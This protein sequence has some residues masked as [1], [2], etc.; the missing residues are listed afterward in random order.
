MDR[1]ILLGVLIALFGL[2]FWIQKSGSNVRTKEEKQAQIKSSY[3]KYL[4]EK[5]SP[6]QND[7]KRLMEEKTK[8]LKRFSKELHRNLFFDEQ[9]TRTLLQE[10]AAYEPQ[11]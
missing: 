2:W 10:L 3:K 1:L 4:D 11:G 6:Y 5:L 9:E 8:I 7:R